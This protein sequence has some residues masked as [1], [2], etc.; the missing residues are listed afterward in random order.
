[1]DAA[2]LTTLL[3]IKVYALERKALL[4]KGGKGLQEPPIEE[5][6]TQVD[7]IEST[8]EIIE[9]E[10]LPAP[11][12]IK[13]ITEKSLKDA[14]QEVQINL[15]DVLANKSKTSFIGES[16][17]KADNSQEEVREIHESKENTILLPKI[18][19]KMRISSYLSALHDW[20]IKKKDLQYEY[21]RTKKEVLD[22]CYGYDDMI[23][24]IDSLIERERAKDEM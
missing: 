5:P 7:Y 12:E 10:L 9:Q 22:S 1:M 6:P 11:E 2:I 16:P 3:E 21:Y 17:K 19:L 24:F 4:L 18:P 14:V 13:K 20:H 15:D 23:D 8:A